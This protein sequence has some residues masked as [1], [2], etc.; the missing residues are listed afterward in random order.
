MSDDPS[1]S[2]ASESV[3]DSNLVS[4]N[5]SATSGTA[6]FVGYLC[7]TVVVFL[8]VL[9]LSKYSGGFDFGVYL[10]SS[11]IAEEM[12]ALGGSTGDVGEVVEVVFD[13]IKE[14]QKVFQ[15]VCMA[16]HQVNG[17]GLP[18]AFPPLAE[19][20]WVAKVPQLLSRIVL[21]GLQGLISVKGTEFNFLMSPLGAVLSDD[22]IANALTYV[23]QEW[24]N[25][26]GPVEPAV[27]TAAR[28]ETGDRGPW[29]VEELA[30]WNN[31]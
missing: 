5:N 6:L 17:Q 3:D 30:P 12:A 4:L 20:E 7:I 25:T 8:A 26:A 2:T 23:R 11:E 10:E 22:Q 24:G 27:V 31:D 14:G 15:T 29:T 13:P 19:S 16:C 28:A 9:Y 21:H 1:I 18:P